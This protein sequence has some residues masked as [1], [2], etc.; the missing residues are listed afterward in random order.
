MISRKSLYIEPGKNT[1]RTDSVFTPDYKWSIQKGYVENEHNFM[2]VKTVPYGSL[3]WKGMFLS[4]KFKHVIFFRENYVLVVYRHFATLYDY[5][6]QLVIERTNSHLLLDRMISYNSNQ[7]LIIETE[8]NG[9]K[10]YLSKDIDFFPLLTLIEL[11]GI[12]LISD[13]GEWSNFLTGDLHDP[14]LLILIRLFYGDYTIETG[15]FFNICHSD[16]LSRYINNFV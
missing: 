12:G 4:D 14:R 15:I 9:N 2:I 5:E 1:L 6:H 8:L 13:V 10:Y 16:K 7:Q 3:L 11:I